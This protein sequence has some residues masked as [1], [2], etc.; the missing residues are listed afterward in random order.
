VP[1]DQVVQKKDLFLIEAETPLQGTKLLDRALKVNGTILTFL[2][3]RL[4]KKLEDFPW[5]ERKNPL[6]G[7]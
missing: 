5:T 4:L 3:W 2:D 1:K 6:G 7:N